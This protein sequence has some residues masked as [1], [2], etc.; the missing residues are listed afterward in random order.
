MS[1]ADGDPVVMACM[2]NFAP[3]EDGTENSRFLVLFLISPAIEFIVV[4][5]IAHPLTSSNAQGY[6]T[7]S[8]LSGLADSGGYTS[9]GIP[10]HSS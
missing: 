8:T 9:A 7:S 3:A 1:G 10:G 5:G 6:R 4:K 2:D